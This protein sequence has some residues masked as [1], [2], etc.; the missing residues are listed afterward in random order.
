[1]W[2]LEAPAP[3]PTAPLLA[4]TPVRLLAALAGALVTAW[5]LARAGAVPPSVVGVTAVAAGHG[6]LLATAL[7]WAGAPGSGPP[8]VGL[9]ALAALAA[10]SGPVGTAAYLGPPA[11]IAWLAARGRLGA[12]GLGRPP[13]LPGLA[14]GALVGL[15]LA[16]HLLLAASRTR[17]YHARFDL[18]TLWPALAYDLGANVL[19]AE[20]FF[21]GALFDRARRRWSAGAAA[22]LATAAYVARYLVDPLLPRTA[23]VIAGAV[24]YLALL[25]F[26]TCWLRHTRGSLVPG[27]L[28]AQVFFAA[29]RALA[30]A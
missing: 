29:W 27:L 25:G 15:G 23:E 14:A 11:W 24:L 3:G 2:S 4:D 17:G 28:S 26:A 7:A 1:M 20:C 30:P 18:E 16:G 13:D 8:A 21:R 19:A 10:R 12:L 5:A 9:L 22:A 6:A